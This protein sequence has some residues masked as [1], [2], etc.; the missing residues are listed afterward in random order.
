MGEAKA[1]VN[2]RSRSQ[3][4]DLVSRCKD[5]Q[6]FICFKKIHRPDTPLLFDKDP[7]I[8]P[9]KMC[10]SVLWSSGNPE[11]WV[12]WWCKYLIDIAASDHD[13]DEI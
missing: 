10:D 2:S 1:G 11:R 9:N 8:G 7:G 12:R 3:N 4:A 13:E 5:G 6:Q